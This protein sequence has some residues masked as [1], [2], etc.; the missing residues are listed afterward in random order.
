MSLFTYVYNKK[1]IHV[2]QTT[3]LES[4][5]HAG[6]KERNKEFAPS[7]IVICFVCFVPLCLLSASIGVL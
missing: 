2:V 4:K 6:T 5:G 1:A 7:K 3:I